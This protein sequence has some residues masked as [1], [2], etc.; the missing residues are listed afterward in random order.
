MVKYL[1]PFALSIAAVI[2][3]LFAQAQCELALPDYMADIVDVGIQSSGISSAVPEVIRESEAEK[4]FLFMNEEDRQLFQSSYTLVEAGQASAQQIKKAP[5][6]EQE[7][8]YFL[9]SLEEEQRSQL[10][11]ALSPAEMIVLTIPSLK[12]TEAF[13]ELNLPEDV[14]LFSLLSQMPQEQF[15]AV[16]TQI[17]AGIQDAAENASTVASAQFVKME[18]R[19]IGINTDSIQLNYIFSSGLRML[20]VALFGTICAIVVTFLASRIAAGVSRN[21]RLAVFSKVENFSSAEFNQFSTGTLITR[22]TNDVQQI[23]QVL[24]MFMRIV[25][26]APII[27]I[28]AIIKVL[29]TNASMTWIIALVVVIIMAIMGI[30]FAVVLPKFSIIQKLL[31]KMNAVLREFLD[32]L[33]VIRA[34]NTQAHEEKRF[35]KVNNEVT[36]T[37]LFVQRTL[38]LLMPMMMLVM[39]CVG[40]LIVWVGGHQIDM[41]TLQVGNMMAFIQYSMQIIMAFLMITMVSVMLP[42]AAVSIKRVM[43]VLNCDLSIKD[44]KQPKAFDPAQHGYVEFKDVAFRYPGAEENVVE[45]ISFLARPGQTTA[46]IG[47]TGSGKSTIVNLVPRFFDVTAGSIEVDGVDIR[48]VSQQEL[49]H[50]IGYV[51]QKGMLFSGTIESNLRYADENADWTQLKNAAEIAQA[52]EFI[53]SK[54]EGYDSPIA[55]GGTN[56]SGGQKQ[57]LSIARAL[58]RNPEIYIFD[59]SFSALDFKTDAALRKALNELCEKTGS[60]VLLVAQRISSIMHADQI[61]VMDKGHIAG[62]GTHD[63]LM[64]TCEVYQEIAYSQLSKEELGHDEH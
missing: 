45:N 63:E 43:E 15:D 52:S 27:G 30:A 17:N 8:V 4:L 29:N 33:P 25:V 31:D 48:E 19:A 16:M 58:V 37:N 51:P 1:K 60:T 56:V 47:S 64:K 2:V 53:D 13:Q 39:N 61:V 44:P 42:R 40:I 36:K 34:F 5:T 50:K 6:A 35:D 49:R 55:Q 24:V 10:S 41:G 23:Q 9:N 62:I 26:Y 38:A 14:D 11:A 46:F 21:L 57:R 32:G 54:P 28:G 59:D 7:P 22:T 20:G 18:Y 3:L 12:E